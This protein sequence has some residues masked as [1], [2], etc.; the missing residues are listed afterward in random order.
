[1][2]TVFGILCI[3]SLKFV[4]AD[5][6]RVSKG[7]RFVLIVQITFE[8]SYSLDEIITEILYMVSFCRCKAVF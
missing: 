6:V 8:F 7:F 2:S 3:D 5:A 1:M 4:I